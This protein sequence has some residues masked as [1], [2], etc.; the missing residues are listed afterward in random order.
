MALV[1]SLGLVRPLC[2]TKESLLHAIPLAAMIEDTLQPSAGFKKCWMISQELE[3]REPA[4]LQCDIDFCF[5]STGD[6]NIDWAQGSPRLPP[7]LQF[8]SRNA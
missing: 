7:S 8:S 3:R 4:P 1:T 2:N 6:L 5:V